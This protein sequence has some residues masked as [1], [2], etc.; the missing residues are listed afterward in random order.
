MNMEMKKVNGEDGHIVVKSMEMEDPTFES[1]TAHIAHAV[2]HNPKSVSFDYTAELYLGKT[3]GSK[4]VTSG[5]KS[6]SVAAGQSKT[7]DF[8]VSMPRLTIPSDS[9]HVYL[10]VKHLGTLLITF[11]GTEDVAVFVNPA[12]DVTEITWT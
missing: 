6:F 8:S 3:P 1:E 4:V 5:S 11:I 10:E 2:F 7:V 12:I 9:Y